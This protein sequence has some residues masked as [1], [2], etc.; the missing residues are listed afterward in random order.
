[1]TCGEGTN[2]RVISIG[3]MLVSDKRADVLVTYGLGSC[4]VVC[5]Y[6]PVVR[7]GGMLHALLPFQVY[8]VRRDGRPTKF[9]D[10]G[11]PLLLRAMAQHRAQLRRLRAYLFGGAKMIALPDAV[12]M[13]NVG[14]RNVDAAHK[15]LRAVH[16]RP[17]IEQTGGD[18]GRTVRLHIDTGK[19]ILKTLKDGERVVEPGR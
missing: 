12:D 2:V 18:F 11:V 6:D 13:W 8:S 3:E 15:A 5:L 10:R 14:E 9:V 7:V 19:I 17:R 4:V 1:M 16:L